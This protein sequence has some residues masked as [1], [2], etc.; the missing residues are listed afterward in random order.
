MS[1]KRVLLI[2]LLAAAGCTRGSVE[3]EPSRESAA[4]PAS[5]FEL[6]ELTIA[7]LQQRLTS[8]RETARSLAEKYLA[9][10]EAVDRGGPTLRSVIELNPDALVEADRLDAERMVNKVRGPLHGIPLL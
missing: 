4:K 1:L 5:S 10:I 7:D 9:R 6:E 8:G 3:P 2:V